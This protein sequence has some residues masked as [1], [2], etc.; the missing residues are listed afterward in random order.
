MT[1]STA[2]IFR[3][4]N[5]VDSVR[6]LARKRLPKGLF[7]FIDRGSDDEVAIVN[8]RTAFERVK[9][10]PRAL[11]DVSGRSAETTVLGQ[12]IGMPLAVAPTGAAGLVWHKGEMA[13]ARAAAAAKVPFTLATR[14]MSSMEDI[15][16]QAGGTLWLQLYTQRNRQDCYDIIARAGKAKFQGLVLTVDTPTNPSR[17][18]NDRNGYSLPFKYTVRG[19]A[20]ILRH[21]RWFAG[22]IGRYWRDGGLPRF[23]NLPGRRTINEGISPTQMLS[24]DLTWRDIEE[25]RRRWPGKLIVKGILHPEDAKR[26]AMLGADAIV[27]SNHGGRN[28]D[29]TMAPLDA[30]PDVVDAVDGRA[31]V[32]MDGGIRRGADIAKALALGAKCVL[33]GRPTLYGTAVAGELG[34]T[35]VL[36]NLKKEFLYTLATLGVPSVPEL[37]RDILYTPHLGARTPHQMKIAAE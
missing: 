34:A 27:V 11:V 7:E 21:P 8:N 25:Y 17:D 36:D 24:D 31:E 14:S 13:L 32:F 30:L 3:F 35:H 28:L 18:Y 12:T 16:S 2:S 6:E 37:S 26:A 1:R 19:V 10:R 4:A 20:D 5:S 9:F 29:G 22:V 33:I 15:A 23:E